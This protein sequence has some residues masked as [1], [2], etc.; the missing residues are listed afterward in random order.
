MVAV[1]CKERNVYGLQYHPEARGAQMQA[2]WAPK[3]TRAAPA[4][5][6]R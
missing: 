2:G 5:P 3:L 6:R 1:E 4:A